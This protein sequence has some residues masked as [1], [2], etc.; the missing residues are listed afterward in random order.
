M[1]NVQKIAAKL[2]TSTLAI[3]KAVALVD[4]AIVL[5]DFVEDIYDGLKGSEKFAAVK[6]ALK[7]TAENLG[8]DDDFDDDFE[9]LWKILG[10]LVSLIVTIYNLKSLW[11]H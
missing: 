10:P 2:A 1:L 5:I 3:D 6:A 7:T 11:K 8:I 9:R 4:E